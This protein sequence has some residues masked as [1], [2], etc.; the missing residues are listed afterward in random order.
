MN[1]T[2]HTRGPTSAS[3]LRGAL[4]SELNALLGS[5]ETEAARQAQIATMKDAADGVPAGQ[6]RDAL[7]AAHA[8]LAA[9]A[10]AGIEDKEL[11]RI[12]AG[13]AAAGIAA[14]QALA[15]R[16]VV[17]VTVS[18]SASRIDEDVFGRCSVSVDFVDVAGRDA[19]L[20]REAP[21]EIAVT[22][23]SVFA[24]PV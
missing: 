1:W 5:E 4:E 12:I 8:A 2:I 13:Q 22:E 17:A 21:A 14:A 15:G 3:D 18:G 24:P 11:R 9:A 10:P 19:R 16:S 23:G 7:L 20:S 6:V